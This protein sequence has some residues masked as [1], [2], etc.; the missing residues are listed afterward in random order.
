MDKELCRLMNSDSSVM[1]DY[2]MYLLLIVRATRRLSL[3]LS[4]L[5]PTPSSKWLQI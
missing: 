1:R 5:L 3:S 2:K 4:F